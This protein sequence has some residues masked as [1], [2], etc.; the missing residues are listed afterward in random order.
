MPTKMNSIMQHVRDMTMPPPWALYSWPAVFCQAA[1]QQQLRFVHLGT[2]IA[3]V[4]ERGNPPSGQTI[5]GECTSDADA[6]LAWDW[7]DIG[8]GVLA[9][10]DPMCVVTNLRLLGSQGEVMTAR[11]SALHFSRL[12]RQLPW[13]DEVWRALHAA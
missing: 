6:G 5:W 1:A 9:M 8:N 13:Q 2:R 4:G 10:A 7:V 11:E 12:V 3:T